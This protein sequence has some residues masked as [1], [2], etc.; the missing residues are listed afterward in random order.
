MNGGSVFDPPFFISYY[1][2]PFPA[3]AVLLHQLLLNMSDNVIYSIPARFRRIENLHIL[4]WLIKDAC[5]A[6]NLHIPALI[7]IVP[8]ILAAVIITWQTR[9]IISELVHNLAVVVWIIANCTWMIGEFYGWDEG[10][11]GLRHMALIPFSIGLL[12]L[13]VY[14]VLYFTNRNFRKKVSRQTD[15]ALKE[16]LSH[17]KKHKTV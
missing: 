9:K 11:Y 13:T 12:I 16:E 14:Y 15:D 8:T 6:L 4:F 17:Q 1:I 7:M 3:T 10:V 5:W 2:Y